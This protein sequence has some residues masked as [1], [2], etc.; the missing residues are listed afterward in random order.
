M[1]KG[2]YLDENP[3]G[4]DFWYVIP[5]AKDDTIV[6]EVRFKQLKC[7]SGLWGV[8]NYCGTGQHASKGEPV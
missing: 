1:G 2:I 3:D 8:K 4:M 7:R 6:S 5:L